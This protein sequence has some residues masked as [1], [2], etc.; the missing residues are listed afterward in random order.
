MIP[1]WLSLV[2]EAAT[3]EELAQ[4]AVDARST[5]ERCAEQGCPADEGA[6]AAWVLALHT[7]VDGGVADGALAATVLALDPERFATLPP[8]VQGAATDPLGWALSAEPAEEEAPETTPILEGRPTPFTVHV[9]DRSGR[10]V[11]TASV[12]FP[13]EG[14]LHHVNSETGSWTGWV[15]YRPDGLE[16]P[17]ARGTR[18]D[19]QVLAAGYGHHLGEIELTRRRRNEVTVTLDALEP[20]LPDDAPEV[21]RMAV[22]AWR[23]WVDRERSQSSGFREED[24]V[25]VEDARRR[26]VQ[27]A[28]DWV[29]AVG[30]PDA[31]ALCLS[32]GRVRDC[33]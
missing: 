16:I 30:S 9:V 7:Y 32:V 12:T 5:I 20:A 18:L 24:V 14:E 29:D 1:M 8:A 17:F 3:R 21:A 4:L 6:E 10:V 13:I 25:K 15:L 11:P 19:V 22:E 28:R 23:R 2:A 26:A 31:L 27:A 33:Q